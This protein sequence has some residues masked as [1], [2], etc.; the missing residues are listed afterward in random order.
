MP[1]DSTMQ[2]GGSDFVWAEPRSKAKQKNIR[3]NLILKNVANFF[4]TLTKNLEPCRDA[5]HV[6]Q[7][8]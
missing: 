2:L 5:K 3:T 8:K 1:V 6:Q 4:C 7:D